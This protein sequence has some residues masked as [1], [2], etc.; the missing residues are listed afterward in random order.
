MAERRK[1]TAPVMCGRTRLNA[2]QA[3]RQS[4]EEL[5]HLRAGQTLADHNRTIS[6]HAVDLKHQL[7]NIQTDRA[8]LAHGRLPSSWFALSAAT[9]GTIDA[10]EWAPSTASKADIPGRLTNVSYSPESGR[11]SG[12]PRCLLSANSCREHVQQNNTLF[13]HLV[14]AREQRGRHGNAEH[15]G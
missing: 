1:L 6:V 10:A 13:D 11:R 4:Y 14:G 12:R 9:L 5:Q 7:R 3:R 2:D 8:N 15:P